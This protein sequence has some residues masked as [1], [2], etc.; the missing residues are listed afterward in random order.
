MSIVH[1]SH[2]EEHMPD[3]NLNILYISNISPHYNVQMWLSD[4]QPQ[5]MDLQIC[6]HAQVLYSRIWISEQEKKQSVCWPVAVNLS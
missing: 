2:D 5:D 4:I 6:A 3:G 1:H